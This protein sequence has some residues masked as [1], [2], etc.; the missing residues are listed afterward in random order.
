MSSSRDKATTLNQY[1]YQCFNTALPSLDQQNRTSDTST[2]AIENV[3]VF[4]QYVATALLTLDVSKSTGID[5]ISARMLKA[6]AL[7]IAPSLTKLFNLSTTSGSLPD[8]WKVARI[9]PIYT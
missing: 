5:G 7:S 9:V 1:F 3:V 8:S 4:E 6:T 2:S